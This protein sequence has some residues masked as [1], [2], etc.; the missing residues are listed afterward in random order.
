MAEPRKH[1]VPL[2]ESPVR[3]LQVGDIVKYKIDSP[4][5]ILIEID[6]TDADQPYYIQDLKT[7]QRSW[8]D[9]ILSVIKPVEQ[10]LKLDIPIGSKVWVVNPDMP[11]VF[12]TPATLEDIDHADMDTPY[13]VYVV[14]GRESSHWTGDIRQQPNAVISPWGASTVGVATPAAD[15]VS[16]SNSTMPKGNWVHASPDNTI[17]LKESNM[18]K[19]NNVVA[20]TKNAAVSVATIQA[21]KAA[22]LAVIR[23]VRP[24][25]PMMIRG[26]MDHPLAPALLAMG[27]AA[28]SEYMPAGP[29]KQKLIKLTDCMMTA[30][31]ADGA[32]KFLDLEV[33]MENIFGGLPCEVRNLLDEE[34]ED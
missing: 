14:G 8:R 10:R 11:D 9:S 28:A 31:I 21:G 34:Y 4:H 25:V 2:F 15:A 16:I 24:H 20:R 18:T 33:L 12:D 3:A 29:N 27:L 5:S 13:L 1:G 26:Y 22:N 6:D 17:R 30:A 7:G 23:A 32:D 19:I